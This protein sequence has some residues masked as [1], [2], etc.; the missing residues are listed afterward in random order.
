LY[1]GKNLFS[2][3]EN[4]PINWFDI[5]GAKPA[6][7]SGICE[8]GIVDP[9][10]LLLELYGIDVSKL[11]SQKVQQQLLLMSV[12]FPSGGFNIKASKGWLR[13]AL[14][15]PYPTKANRAN[16]LQPYDPKTGRFLSPNVNPGFKF[17]PFSRFAAGFGQGWGEA[18]GAGGATPIGR[19]GNI[20]Y[21]LGRIMGNIF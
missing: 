13:E 16:K 10:G 14:G 19:A 12:L 2:Y 17:S 6:F 21:L 18:K 11:K 4:N 15:K 7:S 9:D 8:D 3:T 1:G 5:D 20:G